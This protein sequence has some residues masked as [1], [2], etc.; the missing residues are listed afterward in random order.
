MLWFHART[1]LFFQTKTKGLRVLD[2]VFFFFCWTR[3]VYLTLFHFLIKS[4]TRA[5]DKWGKCLRCC[6]VGAV[7]EQL[8]DERVILWKILY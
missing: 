3:I 1:G 8:D 4:S 2:L 7:L 5:T 6:C